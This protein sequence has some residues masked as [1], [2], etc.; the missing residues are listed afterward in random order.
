MASKKPM[1][2]EWKVY[3]HDGAQA[4]LN[5]SISSSQE[6]GRPALYRTVR[7]E[8][9]RRGVQLIS[10]DGTMLFRTWAPFSDIGN[11]PAPLPEFDEPP[12]DAVTV[13][14]EERFALGFMRTLLAATSGENARITELSL[15][16]DPVESEQVAL[17]EEVQ[18]YAL[19]LH[20][21]GQ[22]LSCKLFDGQ[23]PDWRG[24]Q[25]G[26]PPEELV[27]G[28]TLAPRMFAAVGKLKGVSGVD[29]E[30]RGAERA[31]EWR[32]V[33]GSAPCCGLLMPMRR[34]TDRQKPAKEE[35]DGQLGHE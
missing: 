26:L 6:D 1:S 28:M 18:E 12:E 35:D 3:A 2:G 10:C 17:S 20:A 9:F 31:I 32:A 13:L 29:C 21:L 8:I 5:A 23:Y 30:F 14:D 15:S 16:I 34:P 4:W 22:Q 24:L 19:T 11:L 25:F 27:D 33:H 7:I